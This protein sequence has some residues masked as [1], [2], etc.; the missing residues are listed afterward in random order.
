MVENGRIGALLRSLDEMQLDNNKVAMYLH[1]LIKTN[2]FGFC[3]ET[4]VQLAKHFKVAE[5]TITNWLADLAD[6][7]L[8][9]TF[10][11]TRNHVRR[12]YVKALETVKY[13][14]E[15]AFEEMTEKQQMFKTAFPTKIVDCDV[16]DNVDMEVLVQIIKNNEFLA[17]AE[18]MTLKSYCIR[19]YDRIIA[20][21]FRDKSK[22]ETEESE[23]LKDMERL[24]IDPDEE[25]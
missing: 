21:R 17:N 23:I 13:L 24:G 22:R 20:G 11:E 12:I 7:K 9:R 25:R 4:N 1:L 8:I 19:H 3:K 10:T 16:P 15:P 6:L 18:N 14:E 5:R 2:N